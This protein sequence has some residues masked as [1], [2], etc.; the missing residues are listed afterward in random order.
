VIWKF[1]IS[2]DLDFLIYGDGVGGAPSDDCFNN[3]H[4]GTP[5]M[6][7]TPVRAPST[8]SPQRIVLRNGQQL[9]S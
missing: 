4:L 7:L 8:P 2:G 5:L 6:R 3:N 1:L 9:R